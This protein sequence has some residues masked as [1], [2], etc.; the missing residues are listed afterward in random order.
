MQPV[1]HFHIPQLCPIPQLKQDGPKRLLVLNAQKQED[2]KV[3]MMTL[4]GLEW[5]MHAAETPF[6]G[7]TEDWYI[8]N[9]LGGA[10]P[11]HL[12]LVPFQVISRQPI[13]G[14][15]YNEK[16]Q[17]VNG[18]PPIMHHPQPVPFEPYVT[19]PVVP[20]SPQE[21]GWKVLYIFLLK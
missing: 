12:H 17:E 18:K 5:M 4:N 15:A 9:V 6:V 8:I 2:D 16:W 21:T 3:T 10:H 20:P 11:I 7:S 14:D 13:D 1:Q 19:G